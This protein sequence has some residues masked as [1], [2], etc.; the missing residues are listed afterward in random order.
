MRIAITGTPGTGKTEVGKELSKK[1]NVIFLSEYIKE[2]NL[3]ED[4]DKKRITFEVDTDKLNT[5]LKDEDGFFEGHLS[6]YLD[7]DSIIV[8]RC[9]PRVLEERLNLRNYPREKVLENVQ[10]EVIDV[11]LCESVDTGIPTY[12]IDTSSNSIESVVKIIEEIM[13]GKTNGH[14]PEDVSWD[15]EME[16]WF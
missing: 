3:Y 11:I 12:V 13:N 14:L 7:V 8:L 10:A 4:F 1:Y 16:E 9:A 2:N 5:L 6:H 15:A